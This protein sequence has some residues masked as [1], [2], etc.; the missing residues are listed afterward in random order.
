M[1]L[2]GR[3]RGRIEA[4][5][6]KALSHPMRLCILELFTRDTNRSLEAKP[7][8]EDLAADFPDACIAQ[9]AYHLARLRDAKLL[10][11]G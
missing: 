5:R 1:A 9:V 2:Y 10:P 4:D 7:L 3:D 8:A 11:T 6:T